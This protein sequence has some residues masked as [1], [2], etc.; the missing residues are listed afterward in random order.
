MQERKHKYRVELVD[1]LRGI[2]VVLMFI[3]HFG[4]DLVIFGLLEPASEHSWF[5]W[6]LPRTI[7]TLFLFTTGLSLYL[8]HGK[9]L[10]LKKFLG[11]LIK[12]TLCAL[13]ISVVTYLL[14][15]DHWVYFG[16]LHSI[17]LC[18]VLALPALRHPTLGALLGITLFVL[19]RLQW[20]V[21][22]WFTLPHASMDYIPPFPWVSA[23]L[24]GVA[25]ATFPFWFTW[26][27]PGR[28]G[29]ALSVLGKHSLVIYLLHQPIFFGI[30][31]LYS[32]LISPI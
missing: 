4:Y 32:L 5:W 30:L 28:L 20:L 8:A 9:E 16:T 13:A 21:I 14:F 23:T 25:A 18:S 11:R 12:L 17:A 3:F 7:V 22:P 6:W 19:D 31:K 10:K 1:Q 15:P 26:R 24:L 29:R 2:A 27:L